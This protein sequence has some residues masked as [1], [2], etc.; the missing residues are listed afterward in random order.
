LFLL[1][2]LAAPRQD[3]R[4]RRS[5]LRFL[6]LIIPHVEKGEARPPKLIVWTQLDGLFPR[7]DGFLIPP[8]LHKGHT[9]RMPAIE[10]RRI[11]DDTPAIFLHGRLEV[12][13]RATA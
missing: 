5:G 11:G 9:E 6:D 13:D 2:H 3:A 10:K 7:R 4:F 8:E 1:L 12:A